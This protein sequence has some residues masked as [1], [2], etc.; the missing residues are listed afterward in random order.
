MAPNIVPCG[1]R[2]QSTP[3]QASMVASPTALPRSQ[4][5]HT[6]PPKQW[7][8]CHTPEEWDSRCP[9][10]PMEDHA[11]PRRDRTH[12]IT[13]KGWGLAVTT[14]MGIILSSRAFRGASTAPPRQISGS[15]PKE[16]GRLL[17]WGSDVPT[18]RT[19]P[20]AEQHV[21]AACGFTDDSRRSPNTQPPGIPGE[22]ALPHAGCKVH[23]W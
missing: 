9:P 6:C 8:S 12:T 22:P 13:L 23:S 21:T 18:P 2:G 4:G 10:A 20:H 15:C 1:D 7:G 3:C 17:L 11:L 5:T 16:I 19:Q 14:V